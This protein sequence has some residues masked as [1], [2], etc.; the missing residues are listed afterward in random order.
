[1]SSP[2]I[3]HDDE[4]VTVSLAIIE[5]CQ[6]GVVLSDDVE[7]GSST[8][9]KNASVTS[10]TSA[11]AHEVAITDM[12][13]SDSSITTLSKNEA[14]NAPTTDTAANSS[15]S[16]SVQTEEIHRYHPCAIKETFQ[17][18]FWS[19]IIRHLKNSFEWYNICIL[20]IY[21]RKCYFSK[22][23][24]GHRTWGLR[25]KS[26]YCILCIM[27]DFNM[28][29]DFRGR[30]EFDDWFSTSRHV[31]LSAE[32]QTYLSMYKTST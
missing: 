25:N 18:S 21:T 11:P 13:P 17:E 12:P 28:A 1:M 16:N 9:S 30:I 26:N 5:N 24:K 20:N 27:H 10:A 3:N 29:I 23:D 2:L 4:S 6:G 15:S 8:H 32:S 14:L 19:R 7:S 31:R 22:A